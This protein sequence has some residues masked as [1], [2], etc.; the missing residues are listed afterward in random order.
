[1]FT[2]A[3]TLWR[4]SLVQTHADFRIGTLLRWNAGNT[5]ELDDIDELGIVIDL[6]GESLNVDGYYHIS[7]CISN[8]V[9]HFSPD[10]I[11][12]SL[13]QRQMEIVG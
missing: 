7:W 13:Y 5:G 3:A 12:E 1:M 6:P 11:E 8:T 2:P 9:S 10:M 4:Y